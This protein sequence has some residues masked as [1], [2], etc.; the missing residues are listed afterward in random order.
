MLMPEQPL[1]RLSCTLQ[2]LQA[3]SLQLAEVLREEYTASLKKDALLTQLLDR[4]ESVH[5][6]GQN[7]GQGLQGLMSGM[8]QMLAS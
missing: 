5:L 7:S 4:I 6:G 3:K 8:M 1:M 2:A